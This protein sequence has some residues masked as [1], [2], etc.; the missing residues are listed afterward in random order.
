MKRDIV[1]IAEHPIGVG[2]YLYKYI[3]DDIPQVGVMADEVEKVR[4]EAVVMSPYGFKMVNYG[5]L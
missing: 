5:A 3:W 2:I 4:P 1:R